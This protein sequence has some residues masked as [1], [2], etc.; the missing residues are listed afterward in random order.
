MKILFA[1][2]QPGKIGM[3]NT[4]NMSKPDIIAFTVS[5]MRGTITRN[6][7]IIFIAVFT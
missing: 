3:L 1:T 5:E 6:M 2:S 4:D 7:N